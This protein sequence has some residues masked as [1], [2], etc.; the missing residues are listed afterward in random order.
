[1]F[2]RLN[3]VEKTETF[4]QENGEDIIITRRCLLRRRRI[5]GFDVQN[6]GNIHL[7]PLKLRIPK[8]T[9]TTKDPLK[10]R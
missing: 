3:K 5:L 6:T 9:T 2:N 8:T 1:M 7:K 4:F 10:G